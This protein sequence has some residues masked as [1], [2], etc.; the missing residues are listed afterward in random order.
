MPSVRNALVVGGGIAGMTLGTALL[1]RG[2]RAEV[3][4]INPAWSVL[5]IGISVQGA[6]LRA[7]KAIGV[8]LQN[9]AGESRAQVA[10]NL[11]DFAETSIPA[12]FQAVAQE[13]RRMGASVAGSELV[14]LAPQAAFAG[15]TLSEVGLPEDAADQVFE[16]RLARLLPASA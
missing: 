4:E 14:G 5:G 1:R 12:A 7:L 6:T 15:A 11:T 8:L 10:M 16:R 13:A 9:G 2:I 3:V